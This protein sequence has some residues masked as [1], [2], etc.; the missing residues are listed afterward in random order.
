[1]ALSVMII[2]ATFEDQRH[3]LTKFRFEIFLM[4]ELIEY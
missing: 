3:P 2:A 1:M 4:M